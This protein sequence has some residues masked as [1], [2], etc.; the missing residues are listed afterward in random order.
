MKLFFDSHSVL[1]DASGM[2]GDSNV[3][4]LVDRMTRQEFSKAKSEDNIRE[5]QL[6]RII[7]VNFKF[8]FALGST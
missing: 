5:W 8:S 3:M 4:N 1:V 7:T 6:A 2:Q